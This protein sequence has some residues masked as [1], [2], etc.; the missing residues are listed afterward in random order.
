MPRAT[1]HTVC[2]ENRPGQL[3]KLAGALK[4]AKVNIL[5]ISVV[6]STD[7]G[8]VR[9]LTDNSGKAGQA[10][11]RAG[12]KPT[13]QSVL[14]VRLPN[15]RGALEHVCARLAEDGV[16]VNYAY[17]SVAKEAKQGMLVLGVDCL[18]TALKAL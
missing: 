12:M 6:D 4:R 7:T 16:N 8:L 18:D 14:V 13:R 2:L 3:A 17:G 15:E 9:L 5:A 11:T 1:Q 10:L